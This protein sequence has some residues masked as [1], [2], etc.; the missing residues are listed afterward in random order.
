MLILHRALWGFFQCFD[1]REATVVMTGRSE[2]KRQYLY[3]CLIGLVS[4]AL[5]PSTS[6]RHS[7]PTGERVEYLR[8]RS[9]ETGIAHVNS[10]LCVHAHVPPSKETCVPSEHSRNFLEQISRSRKRLGPFRERLTCSLSLIP[11][12]PV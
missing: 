6:P 2:T 7:V 1:L 11:G 4:G 10:V 5:C 3:I 12:P 8:G 9:A